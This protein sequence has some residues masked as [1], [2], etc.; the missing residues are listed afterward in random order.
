MTGTD[1]VDTADDDA[2]RTPGGPRRRTSHPD[3][4][5]DELPAPPSP[6]E[7]DQLARLLT[8]LPDHHT[9]AS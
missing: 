4:L 7:R 8:R 3:D 5:H 9:R 6:A 2:G 1:A